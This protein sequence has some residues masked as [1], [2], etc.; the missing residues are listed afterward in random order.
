MLDIQHDSTTIANVLPAQART[1]AQGPCAPWGRAASRCL[2]EAPRR[3][4]FARCRDLLG[5]Y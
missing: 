4:P 2:D 5:M 1:Q 3:L